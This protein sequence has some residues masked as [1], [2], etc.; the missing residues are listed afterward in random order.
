MHNVK[1]IA[2]AG[3]FFLLAPIARGIGTLWLSVLVAL[4]LTLLAVWQRHDAGAEPRRQSAER[5]PNWVSIRC[6]NPR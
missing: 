1:G 6:P 4:L 3:V 5:R 2:V